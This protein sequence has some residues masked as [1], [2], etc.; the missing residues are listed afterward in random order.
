MDVSIPYST[1]KIITHGSMKIG[2]PVSI[3]YSTIK[4]SLVTALKI[5]FCVSIPY[6][7]IKIDIPSF[8]FTLSF[9]FQF[10]IV[11][12]KYEAG[13]DSE[14]QNTVSIPYSTIKIGSEKLHFLLV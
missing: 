11:R 3:P 10:L 13:R 7:T 1:I 14:N 8:I 9:L 12:L 6:S 4:I 2:I 5:G